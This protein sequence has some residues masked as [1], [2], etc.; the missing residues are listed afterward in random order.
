MVWNDSLLAELSGE[1]KTFSD[2][3]EELN[4][5][6]R[7]QK[8]RISELTS[9]LSKFKSENEEL[10]DYSID[11]EMQLHTYFSNQVDKLSNAYKGQGPSPHH[12]TTPPICDTDAH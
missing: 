10:A 7:R 11:I 4:N 2:T 1:L 3:L 8:D 9:E 12:S 5:T 6:L